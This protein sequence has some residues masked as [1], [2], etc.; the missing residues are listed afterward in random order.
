M[1]IKTLSGILLCDFSFLQLLFIFTKQWLSYSDHIHIL[2][3]LHFF[4]FY[5]KLVLEIIKIAN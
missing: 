4:A 2:P 1:G 5:G 3:K